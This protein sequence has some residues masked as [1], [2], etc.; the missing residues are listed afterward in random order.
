M[1]PLL[2]DTCAVIWLAEEEPVA[3]A[4]ENALAKAA[5]ASQPVYISPISG[6]EIGLLVAGGRLKF[7]LS[8][9]AWFERALAA[10]HLRLSDLSIQMLIESSF[11]P[12]RPPRDPADRILAASARAN[13]YCIVTR[14]RQLLDYGAEGHVKALAC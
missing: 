14:D 13:G 9:E 2:L 4:A 3:K 8:P 7:S 1:I 6:W 5:D 11:L 12:G 10:P